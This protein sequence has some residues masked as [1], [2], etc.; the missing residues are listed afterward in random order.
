MQLDRAPLR[1]PPDVKWSLPVRRSTE[2]PAV[3]A[4]PAAAHVDSSADWLYG[5]HHQPNVQQPTQPVHPEACQPTIH[6]V[7]MRFVVCRPM[8]RALHFSPLPLPGRPAAC[9]AASYAT[10]TEQARLAELHASN[11]AASRA[12]EPVLPESA[13]NRTLLDGPARTNGLAPTPSSATVGGYA[14]KHA[15]PGTLLSYFLLFFMR[16]T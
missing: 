15:P 8:V 4:V 9:L 16:F 6:S 2:Q 12:R 13:W 10:A 14:T 7:M 3:N 1:D 11:E 5:Y